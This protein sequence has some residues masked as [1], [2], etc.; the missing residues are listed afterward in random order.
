MSHVEFAYNWTIH[1]A[2]Q[3]SLFEVV[4]GFDPLSPLDLSPLPASEHFNLD[5]KKVE[6]MRNLHEKVKL[7]IERCTEQYIKQA[8]KGF[9]KVVFKVEDWV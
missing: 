1:I 2:T 8:N 5:R 7:N 4:Y 9:C 3:I 6:F